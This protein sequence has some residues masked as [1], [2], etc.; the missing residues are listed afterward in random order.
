MKQGVL[1]PGRV[2]LLMKPGDSCF[3]GYGRRRGER[4]RKGVRGCIVSQDLSVL[5]LVIV[6]KGALHPSLSAMLLPGM[7]SAAAI[8]ACSIARHHALQDICFTHARVCTLYRS[9]ESTGV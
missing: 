5:N 2:A 9:T 7:N 8:Q 6:K 3:R 1:T 4:R